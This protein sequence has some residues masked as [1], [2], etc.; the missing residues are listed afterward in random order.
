MAKKRIFDQEEINYIVNLYN[1]G[2]SVREL[3]LELQIS[4]KLL[5]KMLKENEVVL[6]DNT[7]NSRKYSHNEDYFETIDTETKA[8]WL[9]FIYAD[10]FIESKR[11][12]GNQKL[13]IT[14]NSI[15]EEHLY[16]F[17]ESIN[18]TNP[19]KNYIGSGYSANSEFSKIL[20]TSQKTVDDIRNLGVVENKTLILKFPT[21]DQLPFYLIRHFIR[22]YFDGDGCLSYWCHT[23][24]KGNT[25]MRNY[26]VGFIG[27]FEFLTGIS[28][29]FGKSLAFTSKDNKTYGLNIGGR[30]QVLTIMNHLYYDSTVFLDRK[31]DKYLELLKY[32]ES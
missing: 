12:V 27:T 5:S 19:I 16:K 3:E 14:I 30:V 29:Y 7:I 28:N 25:R 15:D 32:S 11:A 24:K 8:Y 4:R 13:G 26:Q 17:K 21:E 1:T 22:G 20:L 18:A 2:K 9:G 31:H 10:G 23:R 6:R